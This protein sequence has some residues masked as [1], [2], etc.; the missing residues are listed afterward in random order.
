MRAGGVRKKRYQ[1]THKYRKFLNY[2]NRHSAKKRPSSVKVLRR[3]VFPRYIQAG[4]VPSLFNICRKEQKKKFVDL[5]RV[6]EWFG[7]L[8]DLIKSV[9]TH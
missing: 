5:Y 3:G 7:G 1:H 6:G 8:V 9:F 2:S 4:N